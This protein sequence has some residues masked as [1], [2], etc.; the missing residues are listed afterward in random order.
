MKQLNEGLGYKDMEHQVTPTVG[1][2]LYKSKIGRD[3]DIATLSFTV[4]SRAVADD[5]VDWFERGYDWIIDA[6]T[7][8]GEVV[9]GKYYVF[10]ETNR[11]TALPAR[12]LELIG[13]LETLTGLRPKDWELII[14]DERYPATEEE[15]SE[16][17]ALSPHAYR[18]Q[19]ETALNE[20]RE[21]A[22]VTTVG[23]Y[24]TNDESLRQIQRQAGIL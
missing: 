2:D 7:S 1:I 4:K 13:D 18:E 23:T 10:V 5:L 19:T 3:S 17:I 22:G 20:W 24:E 6:D 8:P 12:V 21:I 9:D 15:I 11:R 14:D 16:R